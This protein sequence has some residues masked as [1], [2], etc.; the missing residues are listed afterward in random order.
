MVQL[1]HKIFANYTID[2]GPFINPNLKGK[3]TLTTENLL[4]TVVGVLTLV[5]FIYFAIQLILAGYAFMSAEGDKNKL[6][7]ARNKLTNGILGITII[8][9]ALGLASLIAH[10]IGLD[11]IFNLEDMFVKMG[12]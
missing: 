8:V 5:A 2:P 3:S 7:A 4:S 12:L 9:V 6:D 10:I 11:S 1:V